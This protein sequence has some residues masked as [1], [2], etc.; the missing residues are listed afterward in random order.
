MSLKV[1]IVGLPNVGKSTLFKA[2]TKKQVDCANYPFCTIEPNTGIVAVPDERLAKLSA[3]SKS[4]QIIPAAV[5]FVDIAGLVAGASQG[6]GLGNKF[7]SHIRETDA[8]VMVVRAFV[9]DDIVHVHNKIDPMEDIETI[10]L[11]LV[12]ADAATAEKRLDS[13]GKAMKAGATRELA[14]AKSA[15]EKIS[16]KLR[17]ARPAREAELD[18][19]EAKAVCELQLLTM[20]PI[21][22]VVNV[23]EDQLKAGYR[24]VGLPPESQ[25]PLCVKMEEELASMPPEDV[26]EYLAA[27]GIEQTG[28]DSLIG[29]AYKLLGLQT[30]LTTG[31]KETRAWT[32][33][34]GAKAPEAAGVIHTDFEKNFIRAEVIGYEDFVQLG[35]AGAKDAGKMR[36]EGK[37]YVMQEGDVCHFR[38]GG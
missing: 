6:E 22:Y 10:S 8:I 37:D 38:I 33:R 4:E 26:R 34:R 15:L 35:E 18:D 12:Y 21:L 23:D 11:E 2:I 16:E 36:V 31:E 32:Y 9:N 7:L 3:M 19:D 20:K 1:G 17:S 14:L 13:V 29:A 27:M 25:V 28:L 30:F 5:E 24:L